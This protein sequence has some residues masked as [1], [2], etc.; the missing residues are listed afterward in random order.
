M[1]DTIAGAV[2]GGSVALIGLI[3]A[4]EGKTSEF[5]QQ[6]IDGLRADVATFISLALHIAQR[7]VDDLDDARQANECLA[8][9]QLRLNPKEDSSKELTNALNRL[10]SNA[11]AKN[12]L[13][14]PFAKDVTLKAQRVL[15]DEWRRVKR[16]E[17]KYITVLSLASISLLASVG[18]IGFHWFKGH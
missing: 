9:I 18:V 10:E 4:K 16:G 15:K 1:S 14:E 6:W 11:M 5:R 8:R 17:W 12:P 13:T 2:I 3:V 7:L